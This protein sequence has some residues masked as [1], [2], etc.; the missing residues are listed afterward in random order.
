MGGLGLRRLVLRKAA[1]AER[2]VTIGGREDGKAK[3]KGGHP[4]L[5]DGSGRIIGGSVPKSAQG[6][7]I[8]GWWR[9]EEAAKPDPR[10]ILR[11]HGAIVSRIMDYVKQHGRPASRALKGVSWMSPE[12]VDKWEPVSNPDALAIGR[13]PLSDEAL[14]PGWR[15]VGI[16]RRIPGSQEYGHYRVPTALGEADLY[17]TGFRSGAYK[18]G[19]WSVQIDALD[20]RGEGETPAAIAKAIEQRTTFMAE[21]L[22]I[23]LD[24]ARAKAVAKKRA[25]KERAA[26]KEEERAGSIRSAIDEAVRELQ[27]LRIG[28][29]SLADAKMDPAEAAQTARVVAEG[30]SLMESL[31]RVEAIQPVNVRI[32][33]SIRG[34]VLAYYM[35]GEHSMTF[36][37]RKG[38]SPFAHEFGH[39][40][41]YGLKSADPQASGAL[42][43]FSQRLGETQAY[44]DFMR[45]MRDNHIG[46]LAYWQK[47]EERFARWFNEWVP[48]KAA[49]RGLPASSSLYESKS[50]AEHFSEEEM[51]DLDREFSSALRGVDLVKALRLV[52]RGDPISKAQQD[53]FGATHRE[54]A[55]QRSLFGA[56]EAEHYEG[57]KRK[58]SKRPEAG[59][60]SFLGDTEDPKRVNLEEKYPGGAWRTLRGHRV[61]VHHGHIVPETLPPWMREERY[62]EAMSS[63]EKGSGI[64]KSSGQRWITIGG[65][66][67]ARGKHE[68]G[69]P[70]L[71]DGDGHIVG[72]KV[73][74]FFQG[75]KVKDLRNDSLMQ[76]RWKD[77]QKE[78]RTISERIHRMDAGIP[79]LAR[80]LHK[81]AD[82]GRRYWI[83]RIREV[84]EGQM[85]TPDTSE[86]NREI[87]S[88]FKRKSKTR[89][90]YLGAKGAWH[91]DAVADALDMTEN[92]LRNALINAHDNYRQGHSLDYYMDE[93]KDMIHGDEEY[94]FLTEHLK[95]LQDGVGAYRGP[96]KVSDAAARARKHRARHAELAVAKS[97]VITPGG[98]L[99]KGYL[100]DTYGDKP[101]FRGFGETT[102]PHQLSREAE[103]EVAVNENV[104]AKGGRPHHHGADTRV[105]RCHHADGGRMVLQDGDR[106]PTWVSDSAKRRNVRLLLRAA[107]TP[108]WE[109]AY[110]DGPDMLAPTPNTAHMAVRD[111]DNEGADIRI[112]GAGI[113]VRG[114]NAE[115]VKAQLRANLDKMQTSEDWVGGHMTLGRDKG[116]QMNPKARKSMSAEE[117][118]RPA[119]RRKLAREKRVRSWARREPLSRQEKG[120]A[121]AR[122]GRRLASGVGWAKWGG[123]YVCYTHRARSKVYSTIAAMPKSVVQFIESTG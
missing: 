18:T 107:E 62:A 28:D 36:D 66:E 98:Q 89:G 81:E 95:K 45:R 44:K 3:H 37:L 2:W 14:P 7:N 50:Q 17:T 32:G 35:P 122:F 31:L 87:P 47:P 29:I 40:L 74:K 25:A 70:V 104:F 116:F 57:P 111:V 55:K 101:R 82:G 73:P 71:I 49:K 117:K 19:T 67:G 9:V 105:Y 103:D 48:W 27:G 11:D 20:I 102:R 53:I 22:G 4:V 42:S 56:E 119:Y 24:E 39:A 75:L 13:D 34:R 92:A 83:D 59:A 68:D 120:D 54:K 110:R 5:I 114:R 1:T 12:N 109:K 58:Q 94:K 113:R 60:Q 23:P 65:H 43:R 91:L 6:R 46:N 64:A 86:E 69:S 52:L 93:A 100:T 76:R 121:L 38:L 41:D 10:S 26:R 72:G 123:G 112:D 30:F 106:H 108:Y 79:S 99:R 88:Y 8:R 77:A 63:K 33:R 51:A 97:L 16:A 90:H 21:V 61:Y 84:T 78:I 115:R 96:K 15:R 80:Q 118:T 85:I